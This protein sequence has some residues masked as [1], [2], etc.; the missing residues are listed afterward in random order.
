MGEAEVTCQHHLHMAPD[1]RTRMDPGSLGWCQTKE[2]TG[3]EWA[4]VATRTLNSKVRGIIPYLAFQTGLKSCRPACA[5]LL[6]ISTPPVG[7]I[8]AIT[9]SKSAVR[10]QPQH[11]RYGGE[12]ASTT[13]TSRNPPQRIVPFRGHITYMRRRSRE[14][15]ACMHGR[16]GRCGPVRT[17]GREA[18]GREAART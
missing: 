4:R 15:D 7:R 16:A 5:A 2:R 6:P 18:V 12:R 8:A 3:P 13:S 10:R 17:C 1:G 11:L 9:R 14:R